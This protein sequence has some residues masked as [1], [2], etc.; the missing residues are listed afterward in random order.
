MR[1]ITISVCVVV[2]LLGF[3]TLAYAVPDL[4]V[5]TGTYVFEPDQVGDLDYQEYFAAE[6][7]SGS[8]E[9]H[10]FLID[11]SPMNITAFTSIVNTELYLLIT[12]ALND[13]VSPTINEDPFGDIVPIT[14]QFNGYIPPEY[15]AYSLGMI[16]PDNLGPWDELVG[17][18]T[19]E[20][21]Y[22]LHLTFAWSGSVEGLDVE[23]TYVFMVADANGVVPGL[24][25]D[26]SGLN[27]AGPD[28]FSPKT[29]SARVVP[30]PATIILLGMGLLIVGLLG[31]IKFIHRKRLLS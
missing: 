2:V 16:D 27:G 6:F 12:T 20:T 13:A 7:I 10:G 28:P 23:S 18:P 11:D 25:A 1:K 19:S 9:N 15:V 17:F 31:R 8:E 26:G 4:G 22:G 21:Y 14:G 30:E 24:Q 29:D 3:G 5:A